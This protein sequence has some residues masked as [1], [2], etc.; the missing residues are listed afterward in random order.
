VLLQNDTEKNVALPNYHISKT[1]I[2]VAHGVCKDLLH[3]TN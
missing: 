1:K 2:V 3:I